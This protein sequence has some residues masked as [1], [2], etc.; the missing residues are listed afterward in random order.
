LRLQLRRQH[1]EEGD[2]ATDPYAFAHLALMAASHIS[3]RAL[4]HSGIAR[5]VQRVDR[6]RQRARSPEHV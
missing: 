1:S 6:I 3:R 2:S 4:L 5:P